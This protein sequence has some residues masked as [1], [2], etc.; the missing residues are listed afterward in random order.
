MKHERKI[1]EG[2]IEKEKLRKCRPVFHK[3]SVD[4]KARNT[5]VKS[6]VN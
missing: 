3:S 4:C 6:A 5:H 2:E 1:R